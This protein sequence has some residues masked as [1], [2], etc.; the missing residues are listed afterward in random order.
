MHAS[1]EKLKHET[2]GGPSLPLIIYTS[3]IIMIRDRVENQVF[4]L[5]LYPRAEWGPFFGCRLLTAGADGVVLA[6]RTMVQWP[7]P[8]I[9]AHQ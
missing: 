4:S 3:I 7:V 5:D 1:Q 2:S 6:G 8:T 9:I